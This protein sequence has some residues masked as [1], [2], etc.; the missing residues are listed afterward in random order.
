MRERSFLEPI[1]GVYQVADFKFLV[2][3]RPDNVLTVALPSGKVWELD[4]VRGN[5]FAVRGENGLTLDF[6]R[7][8]SGQVTEFSM[9]QA[10]SSR[11]YK[12]T[13]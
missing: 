8:P 1:T 6:K 7:N 12:K 9:D 2:T 11:I 13:Q 4:P 3:L 10:G 5:T